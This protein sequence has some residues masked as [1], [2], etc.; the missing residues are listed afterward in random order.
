MLVKIDDQLTLEK[1]FQKSCSRF[2]NQRAIGFIDEEDITYAE[3]KKRVEELIKFIQDRGIVAGDRVAIIGE[4]SPNWVIAYL[5]TTT[6]GAVAVPVLPEF[7]KSEVHHII[8]HSEAR[9]IFV[10][11]RYFDKVEDL[12]LSLFS[13]VALLDNFA[14]I[15]GEMKKITLKQLLRQKE[16]ELR[17]IG[18]IALRKVGLIKNEVRAEDLAAII[19]TSGT[20]G[21][22]K[23]VMLTHRNISCNAVAGAIIQPLG[24]DD[25]LISL[26]P[27]AHVYECTIGMVLPL[28][29]GCSI[30]YLRKPPTAAILLPALSKVRPTALLTVPLI[31][32]KIY[33]QKIY[34]HLHKGW[35][36][37]TLISFSFLRKKIHR[38]AGKKLLKTFGGELKFFGIGGAALLPE[39]E[40]FLIEAGFPYAI[41]YGLTES[42]P[43]IA[44]CNPANQRFRSTGPV[45]QGAE[46]RIADADKETG[47]GEIQVRGL[48]VMKGYYKDEEATKKAFT[49]DGWLKTGDLGVFD[50]DG[51]LYIKGRIKNMLLGP[52]GENIYPEA[53]ENLLNEHPLVLESLVYEDNGLITARVYL[54]YEKLDELFGA[55]K[56]GEEKAQGL[57]KDLLENLKKE[58]NTRLPSYSQIRRIIEQREP[59]EKTPTQKIKRYLYTSSIR[60]E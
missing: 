54:D 26:L 4:N 56:T 8:R 36:M 43:L 14:L 3:L 6:M 42:A 22:S 15:E 16:R 19:Y 13:F 55:E 49:S 11:E 41:G 18:H 10:S 24:P 20:T 12:D 29:C 60:Q 25:R 51:F 31:I 33:K 52:S 9:A 38:A 50:E 23:G 37:K 46:V 53:I 27:L 2:A 21:H 30:Y 5:A 48:H 40:K 47:I 28:M 34:S 44:G 1:I 7:H 32:E 35:L 45:I 58:V 39:V 59:F 57:I 17:R